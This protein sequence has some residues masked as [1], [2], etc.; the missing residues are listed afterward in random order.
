MRGVTGLILAGGKARRMGGGDKAF[1]VLTNKP[2]IAH[3]IKRIAPQVSELIINAGGDVSRFNDFGLEV[4]A[5]VIDGQAGPLAGILT[6]MEWLA[7]NRA[8]S[9]WLLTV[10]VDTPFLPDD[11]VARLMQPVLD[12]EAELTCAETNG[13]SH[14]VVGLWPAG[15]AGDLRRAML[16][17]DMR[18]IDLWTARHRITH[19]AFDAEPIDP[20]F[21]VNRPED[22][23]AA[24][25]ILAEGN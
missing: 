11:L 8:D 1:E 20:F 5:D 16:D 6:G 2:M 3:V 13:R 4:I 10:P 22:M 24:A 14:P 15:L 21:N 7:T 19:V 17:E 25:K 9:E 18:K 23:E 12:G